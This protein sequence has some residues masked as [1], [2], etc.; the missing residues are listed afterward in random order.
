[1]GVVRKYELTFKFSS[2]KSLCKLGALAHFIFDQD[3]D[4]PSLFFEVLEDMLGYID[5][6]LKNCSAEWDQSQLSQIAILCKNL[7]KKIE[8]LNEDERN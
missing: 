2:M 7:A 5:W 6:K 3:I 1:M 8:G 4:S